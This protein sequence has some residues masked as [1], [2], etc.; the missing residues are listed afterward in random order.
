MIQNIALDGR[1]GGWPFDF[2]QVLFHL[3]IKT[4]NSTSHVNKTSHV[5]VECQLMDVQQSVTFLD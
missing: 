4:Q 5:P 1:E 3:K 2:N